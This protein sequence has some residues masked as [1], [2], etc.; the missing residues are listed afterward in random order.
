MYTITDTVNKRYSRVYQP[1]YLQQSRG[2]LYAPSAPPQLGMFFPAV[3]E[4]FLRWSIEPCDRLLP[5]LN[6]TLVL[7]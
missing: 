5:F 6:R 7:R 4:M 3:L 1:Q 2:R